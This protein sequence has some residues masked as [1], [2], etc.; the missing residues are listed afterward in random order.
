MTQ[1]KTPLAAPRKKRR[2]RRTAAEAL[3][4]NRIKA[5]ELLMVGTPIGKIAKQLNVSRDQVY[6]WRQEPGFQKAYKRLTE[7]AVEAAR[8][9]LAE[10]A[11]PAVEAVTKTLRSRNAHARLRAAEMILDRMSG[12]ES[13][14]KTEAVIHGPVGAALDDA[15]SG[16]SAL[17]LAHYAKFGFFEDEAPKGHDPNGTPEG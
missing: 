13:R 14:R 1:R 15:F 10:A 17:E 12:L 7:D 2:K 11:V 5:M 9:R 16:R 4:A 3:D 8:A 6:Y